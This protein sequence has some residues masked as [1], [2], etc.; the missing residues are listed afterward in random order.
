MPYQFW[1]DCPQGYPSKQLATRCNWRQH[2]QYRMSNSWYSTPLFVA[3]SRPCR[4][5]ED[6]A[7]PDVAGNGN[8]NAMQTD[9][10]VGLASGDSPTDRMENVDKQARTEQHMGQELNSLNILDELLDDP[11]TLNNTLDKENGHK[12]IAKSI[13]ASMLASPLHDCSA[14]FNTTAW[15]HII[16]WTY[17]FMP[18]KRARMPVLE[19]HSSIGK[20]IFQVISGNAHNYLHSENDELDPKKCTIHVQQWISNQPLDGIGPLG[21]DDQDRDSDEPGGV[22]ME[23]G[24]GEVGDD[25]DDAHGQVVARG[26]YLA[27]EL[28]AASAEYKD[29]VWDEVPEEVGEMVDRSVN[30]IKNM[31]QCI[32]DSCRDLCA[33]E[34]GLAVVVVETHEYDH[35]KCG[36]VSVRRVY[37]STPSQM[38]TKAF[39]DTFDLMQYNWALTNWCQEGMK[40]GDNAGANHGICINIEALTGASSGVTVDHATVDVPIETFTR[41]EGGE[42][43]LPFASATADIADP[44]P[45]PVTEIRESFPPLA[46]VKG[47]KVYMHNLPAKCKFKEVDDVVESLVTKKQGK[48]WECQGDE[49]MRTMTKA[50]VALGHTEPQVTHTPTNL[51]GP[52]GLRE[53]LGLAHTFTLSEMAAGGDR[54]GNK[55]LLLQLARTKQ[56]PENQ[57]KERE[58]YYWTSVEGEG[59]HARL[60]EGQR[61][62]GKEDEGEA[63]KGKKHDTSMT[64]S[65]RDNH[66]RHQGDLHIAEV[67]HMTE[68]GGTLLGEQSVRHY[69]LTVRCAQPERCAGRQ[70]RRTN[71]G[72]VQDASDEC[73]TWGIGG[74]LGAKKG[75]AHIHLMTR[76]RG[77]M[78][79]MTDLRGDEGQY[80]PR[81]YC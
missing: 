77:T 60:P 76:Q 69:Q 34:S 70:L 16:A 37:T 56:G 40:D 63:R 26:R 71:W 44:L 54:P 53:L 59:I 12:D 7:Q 19:Q 1:C 2:A 52:E 43:Q 17:K 67:Q 45:I 50:Q 57:R 25:T 65:I 5:H 29:R 80:K 72:E 18:I 41:P 49:L 10:D 4:H 8:P 39:Y 33:L 24:T 6:G 38:D 3:G 78:Q 13:A 36:W 79:M 14:P 27:K 46:A 21:I 48:Q 58:R 47:V 42:D 9:V 28:L 15:A 32:D 61:D 51:Q 64:T 30:R 11:D 62:S 68:D 22:S 66:I 55:G 31:F 23:L 74:T 20:S 81:G 75:E 73:A 35:K